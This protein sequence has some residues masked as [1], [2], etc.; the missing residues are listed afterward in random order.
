MQPGFRMTIGPDLREVAKVQAAFAEFAEAHAL[1][2]SIRRSTSVVL[3]EL[4]NNTISHGFTG[5]QGGELTVEVAMGPDRLSVTLSDDGAPFDPFAVAAP[6][7]ALPVE[8]RRVGGLGIH[9][10]RNMMDEV[11][12]QRRG[13]R[14]VVV[15]AKLLT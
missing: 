11:R 4:L 1:P 15:L 7:T 8:E 14:N 2:A 10:V 13:D 9:L 12:Y 3:D 6:D 5:R